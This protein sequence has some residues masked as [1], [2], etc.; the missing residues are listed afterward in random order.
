MKKKIQKF[1]TSNELS[2]S[3][4]ILKFY[5]KSIENEMSRALWI[6]GNPNRIGKLS[7]L[8]SFQSNDNLYMNVFNDG[9]VSNMV[10]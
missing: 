4:I 2:N 6:K 5:R 10:T 9:E 3:S 7:T 1:K 8:S